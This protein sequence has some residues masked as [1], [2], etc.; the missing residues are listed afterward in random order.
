M[1]YLTEGPLKE[2]ELRGNYSAEGSRTAAFISHSSDAVWELRRKPSSVT[3]AAINTT[4]GDCG[5]SA[6]R[7]EEIEME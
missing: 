7:E 5:H 6:R 2:M 4:S 3:K 1:K